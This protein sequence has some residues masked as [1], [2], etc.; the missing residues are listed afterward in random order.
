MGINLYTLTTTASSAHILSNIGFSI[1]SSSNT[2]TLVSQ[3]NCIIESLP[4]Q[5]RVSSISRKL[6]K[7]A[8]KATKSF[9]ASIVFTAHYQQPFLC[10]QIGLYFYRNHLRAINNKTWFQLI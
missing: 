9:G 1:F 2:N 7:T 8:G 3:L 6:S 5:V 10:T 4:F